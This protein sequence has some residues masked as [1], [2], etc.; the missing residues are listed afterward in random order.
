MT[1]SGA[2]KWRL[3]GIGMLVFS[4][5]LTLTFISTLWGLLAYSR[6][7]ELFSYI[8]LIPFV[9]AYLISLRKGVLPRL[10]NCSPRAALLAMATGAGILMAYWTLVGQG[11]QVNR[12]DKLTLKVLAFLL[13]L[14]GGGF[15]FLGVGAMRRIAFSAG[16]LL[17]MAP[18]PTFLTSWIAVFLQH[19]SAEAGYA[20]LS[21][22]GEPVWR[23]GLIFQLSGITI[24]VA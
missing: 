21:L 22:V 11:W 23:R 1:S 8:P 10:L 24:Q 16:L 3:P 15:L 5:V 2:S 20:L 18:F 14:L 4:G 17:F 6:N 13:F 12:N 19:T 7:S 9:S